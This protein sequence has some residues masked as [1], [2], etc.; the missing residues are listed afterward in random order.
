MTFLAYLLGLIPGLN[1]STVRP[2]SLIYYAPASRAVHATPGAKSSVAC[3]Y[4]SIVILSVP[5][6]NMGNL[7]LLRC[8]ALVAA[9]LLFVGQVGASSSWRKLLST[10][11]KTP[12]GMYPSPP[13]PPIRAAAAPG[14][15]AW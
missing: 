1:R 5:V 11:Q 7:R 14:E 12:T 6:S 3:P 9:S 8:V 13:L 2:W 10:L 15:R 4:Y